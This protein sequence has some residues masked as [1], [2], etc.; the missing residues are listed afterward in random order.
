MLGGVCSLA[1]Y[2]VAYEET[3]SNRVSDF[4]D[5]VCSLFPKVILF[6]FLLTYK[7]V[8]ILPSLML[9]HISRNSIFCLFHLSSIFMSLWISFA[10]LWNLFSVSS[11]FVHRANQ[12]SMNLPLLASLE[13]WNFV[14]ELGRLSYWGLTITPFFGGKC[15]LFEVV[16][17]IIYKS[18]VCLGYLLESAR[19]DDYK[20]YSQHTF[21]W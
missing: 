21:S 20:E 2:S 1:N 6:D 7:P 9:T 17:P 14:L 16:F 19:W 3:Q 8:S 11:P 18:M 15:E 12:S 13:P 10:S 4:R 5:F